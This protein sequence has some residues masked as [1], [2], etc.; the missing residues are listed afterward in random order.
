MTILARLR[1]VIPTEKRSDVVHTLRSL[2]E[3]TEVEPGCIRCHF[4][5]DVQDENILNFVEEWQSKEDLDRHLRS[6]QY[7]KLLAVVDMSREQPE[8]R[9]DTITHTEGMEAIRAARTSPNE[10]LTDES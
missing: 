1:V 6:D 5:Q 3:P 10:S 7:R 4:Y 9:F 2:L 8:I